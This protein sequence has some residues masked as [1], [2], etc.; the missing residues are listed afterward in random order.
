[1]EWANI[2]WLLSVLLAL[3]I[4]YQHDR[5]DQE[6]WMKH[7]GNCCNLRNHRSG[8]SKKTGRQM[9]YTLRILYSMV[10]L[11]YYRMGW[12]HQLGYVQRI[13][14][15]EEKRKMIISIIFLAKWLTNLHTCCYNVHLTSD[16]RWNKVVCQMCTLSL[17][18][19]T[20]LW[21]GKVFCK[22][23]WLKIC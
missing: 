18:H 20:N 14:N 3:V 5:I 8:K 9:H 4:S 7:I 17:L 6:V 23:P 16:R 1:M 13:D 2:N 19:F 15:L 21:K 11:D 10:Q 22:L 12:K